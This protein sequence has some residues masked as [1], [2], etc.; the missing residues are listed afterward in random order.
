MAEVQH[1]MLPKEGVLESFVVE[2][3]AADN[4]KTITDFISYYTLASSVLQHPTIKEMKVN[5]HDV[6]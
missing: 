1:F 6:L 3:V 4:T 2:E 5:V